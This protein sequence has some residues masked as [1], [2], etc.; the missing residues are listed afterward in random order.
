[1]KLN[2]LTIVLALASTAGV[3]HAGVILAPISVSVSAPGNFPATNTINQS[4]LSAPYTSGVTDFDT[5]VASTTASYTPSISTSLGDAAPPASFFQFDFGS[6]VALDAIAIWNQSGSATLLSFTLESSLMSDFSVSQTTG[7]FFI[8][9][10]G[11]PTAAQVRTFTLP[12]LR[13]L[14]VN[15]ITNNG[16]DEATRVNE[17]AFREF[18]ADTGPAVPEPTS[19]ALL[20]M[21]ALGLVAGRRRRTVSEVQEAA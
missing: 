11:P 10:D 15:N 18:V 6:V 21:G 5:Y 19:L 12:A 17:F 7:T 8:S 3:S 1:M 16:F 2:L 20:G 13:Y 4:G 9:E 14:R